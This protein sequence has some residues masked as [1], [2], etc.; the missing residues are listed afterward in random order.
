MKAIHHKPAPPRDDS[1]RGCRRLKTNDIRPEE[2]RAEEDKAMSGS[3]KFT[4]DY[5]EL[6]HPDVLAALSRAAEA[7][8]QNTAYG[9]DKHSA[10]AADA[11]R[12]VFGLP[13][14][15]VF[16]LTGGT[17]TNMTV[18]SYLL[19][20]YEAALSCGTGHINVHETG[21]V[22]GS[23]HKVITCPGR[24]GKILPEE[25]ERLILLHADEHMV[26]PG[27]IYISD[28][29]E[30]GSVYTAS[31]L[32][33]L[34]DVCDR[35]GLYLFID[36]ARLASALTAP[37]GDVTPE[38]IGQVADVFYIGGTKNGLLSGE[39]VVFRDGS[40]CGGFRRHIKNRGAM[41]AKGF[42]LGIQFEA[43]FSDGLF[44]R[45]AEHAN[46]LA[47]GL[48]KSLRKAGADVTGSSPT[49]QIFVRLAADAA[50]TLITEFGLERWE[51]HG[52]GRETVRIV[53]SF[54][55]DEES[56]RVL[57]ERVA[58]LLLKK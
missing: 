54:A 24:D 30:T 33:A 14:G 43:L 50:E 2:T 29:T 46:G 41:L 21:A 1:P 8:E 5:S 38:L 9:L 42:V 49:N 13:E 25:A 16:L 15:E 34:R 32:L 12:R 27:L 7:G 48:R 19:R 28:A 39:A 26:K 3:R 58:G 6:C 22:E 20:P 45:M 51:V 4:N 55:S 11:I 23:G 52:D 10:A 18:I 37:G 31:E 44:F 56:C 36:G 17:Q 35:H 57:G 47:E 53:T 40:L